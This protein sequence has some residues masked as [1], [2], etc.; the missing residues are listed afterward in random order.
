MP[1]GAIQMAAQRINAA[2]AGLTGEAA[3]P[4][5][6]PGARRPASPTEVLQSL[7]LEFGDLTSMFGGEA[8]LPST[9]YEPVNVAVHVPGGSVKGILG[10]LKPD[11]TNALTK[12]AA[13]VKEAEAIGP[14]EPIH[15]APAVEKPLTT[16]LSVTAKNAVASV[17]RALK[18]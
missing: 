14:G 17:R 10:G 18:I 11:F 13:P 3:L 4:T 8:A 12:V 7:P 5:E 9:Q 1:T 16:P 15:L 2:R 6:Q